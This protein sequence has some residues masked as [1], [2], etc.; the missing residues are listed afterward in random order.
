MPPSNRLARS[1]APLDRLPAALARRARTLL[2]R[3]AV[4]FLGTAKVDVLELT[5]VECVATVRN[6]RI[7]QNH[8]GSVHA[9]A[10]ALV[11]ETATGMLVGM[12]VPDSRVPVIKS[13]KVEFKK[14]AKGAIKAVASLTPEQVE[15]IRTEEKGEILVAVDVRDEAGTEIVLCEMIWA[16][17][18]KRSG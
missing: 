12:S 17:T 3:R 16:W 5:P 9:A 13:M 15:R 8:I 2:L 18:P 6:R 4:P 7:V 11:A 10:T 14:R 1:L